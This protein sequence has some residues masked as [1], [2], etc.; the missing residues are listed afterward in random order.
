MNSGLLKALRAV[1]V[2]GLLGNIAGCGTFQVTMKDKNAPGDIKPAPKTGRI[3]F[4]PCVAK[5]PLIDLGGG[6]TNLDPWYERYK[7]SEVYT[8]ENV[9]DVLTRRS[10]DTL[11]ESGHTVTVGADQNGSVA[12]RIACELYGLASWTGNNSVIPGIIGTALTN[13][14]IFSG[15]T[16]PH[17]VILLKYVFRFDNDD[18]GDH[19]IVLRE[20]GWSSMHLTTGQGH[21][22]AMEEALENTQKKLAQFAYNSVAQPDEFRA[23]VKPVAMPTPAPQ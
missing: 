12:V 7:K 10:E 22:R 14:P 11:R 23:L 19:D 4:S 5:V 20:H 8:T 17:T 1:A 2:V 16:T 6:K 13:T 3:H 21:N 18:S 9:L 15:G